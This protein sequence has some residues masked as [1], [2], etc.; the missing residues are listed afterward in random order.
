MIAKDVRESF[1][2][3]YLEPADRLNEVLFGLIMVLTFTLTAGLTAE[4]TPAG[5]RELLIATIGCN[6]AWGIID[7]V[8]FITGS[9]L[10]RAR[11]AKTL[12]DVQRAPDEASGLA[13]VE[14]ALEGTLASLM[15]EQERA[16]LCRTIHTVAQRAQPERTRLR[17]EDLLGGV[18]S[19][20]LV[21]LSTI[22]AVVPFLFIRQP[23][24]ALRVSNLLLVVMLFFVGYA[25]GKHANGNRWGM[26]LAFLLAGLALVGLA[27]ALGG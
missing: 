19:C 15:T 14:R 13:V 1:V 5:A 4:D 18:A 7:G 16:S 9:M 24:R 26:G 11:R 27:V 3:K 21:I 2:R 22:P 25:W 6:I 10:D 23:H 8:M 17:K 20:W 12:M